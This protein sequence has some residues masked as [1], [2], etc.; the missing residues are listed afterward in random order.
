MLL[1]ALVFIILEECS[2]ALCI[3][4]TVR[5][6]RG[7][8][9]GQDVGAAT[10]LPPLS[11]ISLSAPA[12]QVCWG[13][14]MCVASCTNMVLQSGQFAGLQVFQP[15]PF[16]QV[17]PLHVA[18]SARIGDR[19]SP[20]LSQLSAMG[21]LKGKQTCCTAGC[22]AGCSWGYTVLREVVGVSLPQ[23]FP[24]GT[25]SAKTMLFFRLESDVSLLKGRASVLGRFSARWYGMSSPLLQCATGISVLL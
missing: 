18:F 13:T 15:L 17:C 10:L 20:T 5:A 11:C 21:L 12:P 23:G 3:S 8:C 9:G 22:T 2:A 25:L 4:S 1:L 19:K 7:Q 16:V 24:A 6:G 14:Y